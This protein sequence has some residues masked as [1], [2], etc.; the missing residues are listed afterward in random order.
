MVIHWTKYALQDLKEFS[1]YS[2]KNNAY[3]YIENLVKNVGAALRDFPRLGHIYTYA[4]QYIIRKYVYKEHIIL[5]YLDNDI[6]HILVAVYHKQ[7]I[8][9]KLNFIK[10][11]VETDIM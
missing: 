7:D 10:R 9:P 3:E 1:K 5:Y 8:N 2:K 4:Q 6:I 11:I